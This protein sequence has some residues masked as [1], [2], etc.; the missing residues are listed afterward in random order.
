MISTHILDTGN[1]T[2]ANDVL[3]VLEI[4]KGKE[5]DKIQEAKTN[6][7]GRISFACPPVEGVY[8]LTFSIQDYF[9]HQKRESFFLDMPVVFQIKD[10]NRKYHVPLLIN[11]FGLST[12][13]GS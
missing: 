12:Y 1:G 2:P 11:S 3:V 13:R 10:T 5:W 6:N 9:A 4:L 7:D 8:R